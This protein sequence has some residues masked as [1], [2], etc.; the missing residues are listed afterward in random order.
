MAV[1]RG[2]RKF[3]EGMNHSVAAM[4]S[5]LT[6]E[7][8]YVVGVAI[9]LGG[10]A[11][12]DTGRRETPEVH[13]PLATRWLASLTVL[14]FALTANHRLDQ[15]PPRAANDRSMPAAIRWALV[16]QVGRSV[17]G[18]RS[19]A[20]VPV[21][22]LRTGRDGTGGC[23][24]TGLVTGCVTG[25]D[26]LAEA[27]IARGVV[28]TNVTVPPVPVSLLLL[29]VVRPPFL[30]M[31]SSELIGPVELVGIVVAIDETAT[32]E[33]VHGTG[34]IWLVAEPGKRRDRHPPVGKQPVAPY[35]HLDEQQPC[36]ARHRE[37]LGAVGEV[38]PELRPGHAVHRVVVEKIWHGIARPSSHA[39]SR[40][41]SRRRRK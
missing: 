4:A 19:C 25:N 7:A 37:V 39:H 34:Q 11:L 30:H 33:F 6:D 14:G 8:G 10:L 32:D 20:P 36:R 26:C 41:A 1:T 22:Y 5:S 12:M 27:R 23:L 16:A 21:P 40:S 17:S 38:V 29:G 15:T 2:V 28:T 13:A 9:A 24:V 18:A 35:E 3:S 31:F